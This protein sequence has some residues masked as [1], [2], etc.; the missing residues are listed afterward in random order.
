MKSVTVEVTRACNHKC[1]F[2][3]NS[4]IGKDPRSPSLKQVEY[5][6]EVLADASV[7]RITITGGEPLLYKDIMFALIEKALEKGIEPCLNSNLTLMTYEDARKLKELLGGDNPIFSSIPSVREETCDL[8]TGI[9]GSYRLI[10]SGI[11]LCKSVGLSIGLNMSVAN[12]NICDIDYVI[13]FLRSHPVDFFTLF[14]VIPP[15]KDRNNPKYH[16]NHQ[17]VELIA[18]KLVE[19]NEELGVTVGSVRPLPLCAL[20]DRSKYKIIRGSACTTGAERCAI[21]LV[22]GSIEACSQQETYYGN[23]YTDN[24]LE[25][26]AHLKNDWSGNAFLNPE[27]LDC[28]IIEE[29]GGQCIWDTSCFKC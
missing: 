18:D 11:D 5:V 20:K 1:S 12:E 10:I 14:K 24:F 26:I 8:I 6:I 3:Y 17:L 7:E 13:P 23:I 15:V 29:C 28:E 19:I 27:C 4:G 25:S 21:N 2:C 9:K 16:M 22:T